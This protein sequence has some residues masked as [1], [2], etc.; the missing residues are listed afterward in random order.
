MAGAAVPQAPDQTGALIPC[1]AARRVDRVGAPGEEQLAPEQLD[2]TEVEREAELVDVDRVAH[3]RQGTQVG[4]DRRHVVARDH[5]V[6]GVGHDWVEVLPLAVH[7]VVHRPVELGPAPAAD[8]GVIVGRDV[9]A[10]DCPER[11]LYLEAAGERRPAFGGMAGD[12]GAGPRQVLAAGTLIVCRGGRCPSYLPS[13][14]PA[15]RTQ[16]AGSRP[17]PCTIPRLASR[18]CGR[19]V[20]MLRPPPG[21]L[22]PTL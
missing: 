4:K 19:P 10:H 18:Y 16:P 8:A 21:A 22:V 14:E 1:G 17:V 12:A 9:G 15:H 6:E 13:A 3:R 20:V 11:R 5:G 2:Q 7:A